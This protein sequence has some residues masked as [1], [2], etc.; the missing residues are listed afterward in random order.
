MSE[1]DYEREALD[2]HNRDNTMKEIEKYLED[3][4]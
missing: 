3:D 4:K 1:D 2:K